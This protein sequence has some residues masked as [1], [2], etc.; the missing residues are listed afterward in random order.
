MSAP[1]TDARGSQHRAGF[2]HQRHHGPFRQAVIEAIIARKGAWQQNSKLFVD[3]ADRRIVRQV[4]TGI[5]RRDDANGRHRRTA[6]EFWFP[7]TLLSK[8]RGFLTLAPAGLSPAEHA[9][10]G[11]VGAGTDAPV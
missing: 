4:T 9:F 8:L 3:P 6:S 1:A 2:R 5:A 10:A 7:A 11:H